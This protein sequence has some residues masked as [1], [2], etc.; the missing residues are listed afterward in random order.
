[1]TLLKLLRAQSWIKNSFVIAPLLY[2]LNFLFIDAVFRGF[3][4]FL[5]FCGISSTVYILNDIVDKE[6]DKQHPRKCLRPIPSG[7]ISVNTALAIM[8]GLIVVCLPLAYLLSVDFLII[9]CLYLANNLLYTFWWKHVNLLDSFSIGISF[10]LRTIG[11]C[12]AIAVVPSSWIL[13]MTFT[14][15]LFL[16]FIKRKSEL[17]MLGENAAKHRKVLQHYNV[18]ILN[19][20]IFLC[21]GITLTSYLLYSINPEVTSLLETD[22]LIYSSLFVFLGI[23]RFLQL[24]FSDTYDFEGDPTTLILKDRFLQLTAIGYLIFILYILY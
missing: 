1:M 18:E 11:G 5:L 6:A 13:V 16:I 8:V 22:S 4:A 9:I 24:C 7:K 19:A 15:S 17:V 20:Y 10:V 21:A 14:L 12:V 23:F 2:S 3:S